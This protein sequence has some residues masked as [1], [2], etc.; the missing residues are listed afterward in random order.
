MKTSIAL[1]ASLATASAFA[2]TATLPCSRT[3]SSTL[4]ATR[5]ESI[6]QLFGSTA[7]ATAALVLTAAQPAA[8]AAPSKAEEAE[9]NELIEVLKTRS[10]E[11]SEAN[12]NYAMRANKLAK[13]DFDDVKTRRPKL[14]IVSTT[15]GN[16]ILTKE[17]FSTYNMDGKIDTVYGTRMKQGGGEM[18]DYN[19]I[20]YVLKE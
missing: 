3:S 16:K 5:R 10:E 19:D 17:E 8:A 12:K 14:I 20:T 7:A 18:K 13:Q 6:E 9:F 2:P 11:N 4:S 1:I 15:K